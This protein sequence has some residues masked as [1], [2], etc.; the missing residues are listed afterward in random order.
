MAAGM[1]CFQGRRRFSPLAYLERSARSAQDLVQSLLRTP[2][3][4]E[5]FILAY[6]PTDG[7]WLGQGILC[8]S[9]PRLERVCRL[10]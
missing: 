9:P 7:P 5:V 2:V 4:A 6:N 3:V 1:S 10:R 8:H